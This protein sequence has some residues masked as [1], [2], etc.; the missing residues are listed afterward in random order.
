MNWMNYYEVSEQRIVVLMP[1]VILW[2]FDNSYFEVS[3][4]L[5]WIVIQEENTVNVTSG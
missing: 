5:I 1:V 4:A 2:V 3:I